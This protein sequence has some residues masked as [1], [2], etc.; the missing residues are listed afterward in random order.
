MSEIIHEAPQGQI[1]ICIDK[2]EEE[3]MVH[4]LLPGVG[5]YLEEDSLTVIELPLS[6]EKLKLANALAALNEVCDEYDDISDLLRYIA[7]AVFK[8]S[9]TE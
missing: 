3:P 4:V 8:S 5:R 9:Q 6:G 1:D 2:S 7:N